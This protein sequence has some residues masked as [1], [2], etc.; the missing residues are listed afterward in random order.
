MFK[1]FKSINKKIDHFNNIFNIKFNSNITENSTDN[2]SIIQPNLNIGNCLLG[3]NVGKLNKKYEPSVF[4]AHFYKGKISGKHKVYN[5]FID[6]KFKG[7]FDDNEIKNYNLI[8]QSYKDIMMHPV[9]CTED[10]KHI[11]I[12]VR[13]RQSAPYSYCDNENKLKLATP[14]KLNENY[15]YHISPMAYRYIKQSNESLDNTNILLQIKN[16]E[17]IQNRYELQDELLKL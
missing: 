14:L 10:D 9:L 17:Y 11:D 15:K 3:N 7:L 4:V 16:Y 6:D 8:L 12:I 13:T 2:I 5:N 1:I